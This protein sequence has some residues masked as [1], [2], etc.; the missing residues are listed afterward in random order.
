MKGLKILI[1]ALLWCTHSNAQGCPNPVLISPGPTDGDTGVAVDATINW[2]TVPGISNYLI[3]IGTTPLGTDIISRFQVGSV[4]SFT[5]PTGLPAD[6][7]I[8]VTVTLLFFDGSNPQ[9]IGC[10]SESFRTEII[11]SPPPCTIL[12]NPVDGQTEVN[13]ATNIS[14]DYA[15]SANGYFL[16]IGTS[17]GVGDIFNGDVGNVLSFNPLID[18]P[19]DTEIFV[20]VVPYND[21]GDSAPCNSESFTTGP[22]AALPECTTLITPVNGANNVPLTPLLEWTEVPGATGY[23]VTIGTSPF[24]AEVLSNTTFFTNSTFVINFEPNKTFFVTIIPFN[25]AGE[26]I[27]CTQE[28]FSTSLGCGPFI[29][30]DTGELV[31][32]NP[33]IDFPEAFGF[34]ENGEPLT[35]KS[36]DEADGFRWYAINQ[37]GNEEIISENDFVTISEVGNYRYE[38]YNT[39]TTSGNNFDCSTSQVFSV[40]SS[41]IATITNIDTLLQNGDLRI[42][43]F[44]QGI[45]DY[46]YALDNIDGPYQDSPVFTNI[47]TG[48]H[49]IFVRDRNGCGIAEQQIEQD[50]TLEGFPKFFTPNGDGVNDFW[51]FIPPLTTGEVNLTT[52][53]IFDRF[54][55]LLAQLDPLSTGWDGNFNGSP[56]PSSDYWFRAI[57]SSAN[58]INGHFALKR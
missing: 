35:I 13:G 40:S 23:R 29:Q 31:T 57:D 54:G 22:M 19:P 2:E 48:T 5:P 52:I 7:Q 36:T 10:D 3:S 43:V 24:T 12:S 56:L 4:G 41:Q 14:W 32:L 42:E 27:G 9:E 26:A 55:T 47:P 49:T 18:L 50:L 53:F 17:L 15:V 51:Q 30:P 6:T 37:F 21:I 16:S 44:V 45:G 11:S 39:I 34:C 28:F 33:T 20:E 46:E 38:A 8:Y 1:L 58:E 25:E